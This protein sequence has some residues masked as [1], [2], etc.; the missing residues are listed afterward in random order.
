MPESDIG[1]HFGT[2]LETMEGSN[3]T[4][5]V[6]GEKFSAHKLVLTARSI[7]FRSEFFDKL[8]AD[9]NEIIVNDM[10]PKV[11]KVK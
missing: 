11:F 2:L 6:R 3:L 9:E 10:E 7:V 4:F 1:L 8:K 5:N